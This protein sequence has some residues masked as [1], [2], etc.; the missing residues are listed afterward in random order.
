MGFKDWF[1]KKEKPPAVTLVAEAPAE[2]DEVSRV[3]NH[4][5]KGGEIVDLTNRD[6]KPNDGMPSDQSMMHPWNEAHTGTRRG[7]S[8]LGKG[9]R[10]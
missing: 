4:F 1:K 5:A 10:R 3:A 6:R 9:D 2:L 7:L 8:N